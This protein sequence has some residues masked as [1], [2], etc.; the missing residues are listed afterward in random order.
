MSFRERARYFQILRCHFENGRATTKPRAVIPRTGAQLQNHA[1]SFRGEAR[2]F[3]APRCRSE[4]RR[5]PRRGNLIDVIKKGLPRLKRKSTYKKRKLKFRRE[6]YETQRTTR[7][8]IRAFKKQKKSFRKGAFF[9]TVRLRNDDKKRPF[10]N[11]KVR[12]LKPL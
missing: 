8:N 5:Q 7:T 10:R 6:N 2:Y 3:Q 11:G 9:P 12:I 1:L 4:E